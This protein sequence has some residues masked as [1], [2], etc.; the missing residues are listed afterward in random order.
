MGST[1]YRRGTASSRKN[2][3][4]HWNPDCLSYP[5]GAYLIRKDKPSDDDLCARCEQ[6]QAEPN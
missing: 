3:L 6:A 2:D 5:S 1:E 4:W